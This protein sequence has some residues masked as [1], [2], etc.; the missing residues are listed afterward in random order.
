MAARSG[1]GGAPRSP[2]SPVPSGVPEHCAGGSGGYAETLAGSP[3]PGEG[4]GGGGARRSRAGVRGGGGSEGRR[5]GRQVPASGLVGTLARGRRAHSGL[6]GRGEA[7]GETAGGECAFVRVGPG[8]SPGPSR[9][10]G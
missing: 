1:R 10:G 4:L 6:L 5:R 9:A 2:F 8:G 3:Q 7:G